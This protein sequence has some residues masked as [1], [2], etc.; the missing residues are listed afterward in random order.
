MTTTS[1]TWS[2]GAAVVA[3]EAA[4]AVPPV[5]LRRVVFRLAGAFLAAD[6]G[7]A[8]FEAAAFGA[9]ALAAAAFDAGACVFAFFAGALAARGASS[10]GSAGGVVSGA[11]T[12]AS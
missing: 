9:G 2:A 12:K 10:G 3:G 1:C 8:A 4:V 5:A 6:L 7:A 11:V